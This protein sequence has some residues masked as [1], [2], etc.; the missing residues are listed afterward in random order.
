MHK[1]SR[2]DW[3][4]IDWVTGQVD[5]DGLRARP[6]YTVH[7][8]QS[9]SGEGYYVYQGSLGSQYF[10]HLGPPRTV[11]WAPVGNAFRVPTD[12][13]Q[14]VRIN[15]LAI[16]NASGS[17]GCSQVNYTNVPVIRRSDTV[18]AGPVPI[19]TT[20]GPLHRETL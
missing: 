8:S 16:Q 11:F 7:P 15:V 3:W 10:S 9:C 1:D 19:L 18:L 6:V 14:E 12:S 5:Q 17:V 13:A 4:P 2:G 20:T